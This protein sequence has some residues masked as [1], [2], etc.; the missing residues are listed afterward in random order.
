MPQYRYKS[1]ASVYSSNSPKSSPSSKSLSV[2]IPT[3]N[4]EKNIERLV[5]A[6]SLVLKGVDFEIVVVDDSSKDRTPEII[7]RL[8]A[9]GKGRIAALHR[10]GISGIFS[11]LQDG[12]KV[13]R[14]RIIV[15]M[16]A[17]FS[18]P[19]ESVP[20][21]VRELQK[22]SYDIVVGSRFMKGSY[23]QAPFSRK[24]GPL[25]LN[26]VCRLILCLKPTDVFTGFHAMRK[27]SFQKIR[28]KYPS[29]W[30]EFDMEL[31]YR[32]QKIGFRMKDVPFSYKFRSEGKSKSS[33]LKIIRFMFAYFWRALQLRLLR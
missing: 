33:G 8:A 5:S 9:K 22:G 15:I 29:V 6:L 10:K 23:F 24:Y 20:V 4:E 2:I 26:Q 11:A 18:H 12:I 19:P 27:E 31:L 16:D 14:G 28:F 25:L 1:G 7:D 3:F 21:L 17:D 30:G 13:S 32:A